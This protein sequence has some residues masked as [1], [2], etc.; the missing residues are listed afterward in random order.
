VASVTYRFES[1]EIVLILFI[2][3]STITN[4]NSFVFYQIDIPSV[5]QTSYASA[6]T[7]NSSI[8][9]SDSCKASTDYYEAIQVEV[10]ENGHYSFL[11]TSNAPT[12][13]QIFKDNFNPFN[14][15]ENLYSSAFSRCP[16][17]QLKLVADLQPNTKYVF[18]VSKNSTSVRTDFS[19]SVY[20]PKNVTLNHLSEYF[21]LQFPWFSRE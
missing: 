2:C 18:V 7:K 5:I 11:I 12:I 16:G 21:I 19:I 8:F 15:Y 9:W 3:L 10:V 4:L 17:N 13:T 14:L 6:L 20:G 1:K